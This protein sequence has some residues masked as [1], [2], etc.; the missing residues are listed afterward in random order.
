MIEQL[1]V[2]LLFGKSWKLTRKPRIPEKEVR[3]L[4]HL[5]MANRLCHASGPVQPSTRYINR[6]VDRSTVIT[7]VSD[8]TESIEQKALEKLDWDSLYKFF[9]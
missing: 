2:K 7:D 9:D 5:S 1:D 3:F 8:V 6:L 4:I